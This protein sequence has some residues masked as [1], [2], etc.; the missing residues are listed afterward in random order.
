MATQLRGVTHRSGSGSLSL[1]GGVPRAASAA[2]GH[3]TLGGTPSG[4]APVALL[5]AGHLSLGGRVLTA[6][7]MDRTGVTDSATA[8]IVP[9]TPSDEPA[10][11]TDIYAALMV[12]IGQLDDYADGRRT[13]NASEMTQILIAAL[14]LLTALLAYVRPPGG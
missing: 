13:W 4:S 3:L 2:T 12:V 8:I 1:G 7:I 5:A 10:T 9:K 11:L 14:A 6:T